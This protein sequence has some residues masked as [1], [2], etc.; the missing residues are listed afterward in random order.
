MKRSIVTLLL[1]VV[2][3]GVVSAQKFFVIDSEKVFKSVA[4]YNEAMASLDNLSKEYQ[5]TVEAKYQQV[6][7]LYNQYQAQKASLSAEARQSAER[8]IL[9]Q[10]QE[11]QQLQ[12]S[13]FGTEGQLMKRRKEL[14]EPVQKRVFAAIEK[15]AKQGG[16]DLV[17]DK[18][19]NT[20]MLYSSQAVD[21]TQQII[22][23]LK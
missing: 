3:C 17:L 12:Q 16:Y 21:H 23:M 18:A 22:E 15:F 14:I 5:Q 2:A 1:A 9:A 19:S 13:L 10:E 11:A 20:T 7:T 8:T 4:A 6:E